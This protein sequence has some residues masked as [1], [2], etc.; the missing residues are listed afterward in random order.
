VGKMGPVPPGCRP[1]WPHAALL[2][3]HLDQPNHTPRALPG[4]IW[5]GNAATWQVLTGPS[6][7]CSPE[8]CS[9]HE[10]CELAPSVLLMGAS[11][12]N[13]ESVPES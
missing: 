13:R 11:P 4:T 9:L 12:C 2:V 1:K 5:A 8:F 6:L 3:T 7:A 10:I